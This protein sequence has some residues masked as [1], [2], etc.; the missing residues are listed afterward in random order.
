MVV[1][2]IFILEPKLHILFISLLVNSAMCICISLL[3][4]VFKTAALLMIKHTK[5]KHI[6]NLVPSFLPEG[7]LQKE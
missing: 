3:T 5:I 7:N 6:H 1:F 4:A 2:P